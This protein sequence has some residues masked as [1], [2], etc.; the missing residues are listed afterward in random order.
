[1]AFV[2]LGFSASIR[3]EGQM[4]MELPKSMSL[5]AVLIRFLIL[6]EGLEV[7]QVCWLFLDLSQAGSKTSSG[8]CATSPAKYEH[9]NGIALLEMIKLMAWF[10]TLEFL[11]LYSQPGIGPGHMICWSSVYFHLPFPPRNQVRPHNELRSM[12]VPQKP[13][14]IL[15]LWKPSSS[16]PT[17]VAPIQP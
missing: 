15:N 3:V 2:P 13:S 1:V 5:E 7:F 4:M 6:V 10:K 12:H 8:A 17:R 16:L 11:E 14:S 9:P